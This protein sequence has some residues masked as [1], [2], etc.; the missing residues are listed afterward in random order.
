MGSVH[1]IDPVRII[2]LPIW[3]GRKLTGW[4]LEDATFYIVVAI[5]LISHQLDHI[6]RNIVTRKW[7]E[8]A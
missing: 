3:Y 6:V 8:N 4:R 7:Q 2:S 1:A 5:A